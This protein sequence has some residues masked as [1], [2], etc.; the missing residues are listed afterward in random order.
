MEG[1]T[2]QAEYRSLLDNIGKLLEEAKGRVAYSV[3]TVLVQTYWTI[4]R[5]IVEFEQEGKERAEYGSMLLASLSR[6]IT[7]RYGRGFNRNNLQ[8]MRKFFLVFQNC[9]TA[10]CNSA[11]DPNR[12]TVSC[13]LSWSHYIELLKLDDPL[14]I[15]FY[16]TECENARWSVRE[17]RRQMDSQLFYRLAK[18]KDREGVLQLAEKG[19]EMSTPKDI[20]HDPYVL[21]FVDLPDRANYKEGELEDALI[22]NLGRFM[23]EL[24]KGFAYI[25]RQFRITLGGRHMY[26]D[27]V[28]YNVYLKCYCL[29]DLKRDAIQHEDIGQMNLYLNY[30]K[31]EVNAEG[32]NEPFGIV[33]GSRHDKLTMQYA[34]Q[35]ISNNLFVSRYQLYLPDREALEREVLRTIEEHKVRE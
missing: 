22:N 3:N 7:L 27:L 31:N 29:I 26:V 24:G 21:E 20:I 2:T 19:I 12:P 35:G 34:L 10:S 33:L 16:A 17:L 8:Y 15:R 5:Y 28:F 4:G 30:F 1:L 13:N 14:E 9:T 6:D 25:G 11:D 18:S 32:D 23:L